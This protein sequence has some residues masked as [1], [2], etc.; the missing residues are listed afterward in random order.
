MFR[1]GHVTSGV[2]RG[3][4]E[5]ITRLD[6]TR[7]N[8]VTG[9]R[10]EELLVDVRDTRQPAAI[11]LI[12]RYVG[13]G[14]FEIVKDREQIEYQ[15]T[16]G[17]L[18]VLRFFGFTPFAQVFEIGLGSLPVL[19][20]LAGGRLPIGFFRSVPPLRFGFVTHNDRFSDPIRNVKFTLHSVK[21]SLTKTLKPASITL[22]VLL[23]EERTMRC[24][25]CLAAFFCSSLLVAGC[26]TPNTPPDTGWRMYEE[27]E[28]FTRNG[29][30]VAR[31][32]IVHE[33]G[34]I[35]VP[36]GD[37]Y[38]RLAQLQVQDTAGATVARYLPYVGLSVPVVEYG[39]DGVH[40]T[41]I[42]D[43]GFTPYGT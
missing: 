5:R 38:G 24:V 36:L 19:Q 29:Q 9:E 23:N 27:V 12:G 1:V 10:I 26:G 43:A 3:F 33:P 20:V 39:S 42:S 31:V 18:G 28:Q 14:A 2:H 4:I 30:L 32:T 34:Q 22:D 41:P 7:C 6:L 11:S 37:A 25:S 8:T 40:Y 16:D 21:S 13:Q 15:L 35:I 17:K